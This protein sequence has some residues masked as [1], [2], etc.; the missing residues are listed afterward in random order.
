MRLAEKAQTCTHCHP[1]G[2]GSTHEF[3]PRHAALFDLANQPLRVFVAI[4]H[5]FPPML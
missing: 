2:C 3:A 5:F 1:K 4:V